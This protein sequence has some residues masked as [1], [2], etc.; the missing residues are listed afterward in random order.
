[1]LRATTLVALLIPFSCVWAFQAPASDELAEARAALTAAR[2]PQA[3]DLFA[4][5]IAKE[6]AN[7]EAYYGVVRA[8]L[9]ARRPAEAYAYAEQG[10]RRAPENA[11]TEDAA[12]IAL[13]RKGELVK[14]EAH[15]R[16][17]LKLRG[18]DPAA[19][20]GMASVFSIISKF[21]TS[22]ALTLQAYAQA[23]NDPV[24]MLAH[25]Y[26]LKGS[27]RIQDLERVLALLDPAS[28][29][30]R[31]LH[32]RIAAENAAAG[33]EL[34]RLI[35]PYESTRV[36]MFWIMDGLNKRRGVHL[37]VQFNQ[38][39]TLR[40]LLDTGASGISIAPRAAE[41]AGL[42]ILGGEGSDA[43]GIGDDKA[44]TAFEYLAAE[45]R[46]GDVAFADYPV[47]VFRGAQSADFDGLIGADVFRQ[48]VIGI[49]FTGLELSLD[50]RPG[51]LK[52]QVGAVDAADTVPKG[53]FR[54]LRF[55]NHLALPTSPNG[56]APVIFLIDSGAT[57][58]LIDVTV[59]RKSSKIYRDDRAIVK[60]VQG[61]VA[62]VNRANDI[63]LAF[64][65]FRQSNPDLLAIDLT[66]MSDD[67][68]VGFAGILGMPVLSQMKLTIDYREGVIRME[69]QQQPLPR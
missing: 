31:D 29:D 46:I 18:N 43:K 61:K 10:L 27:D 45:V 28:E 4:A 68:G 41:K 6:P 39:Q 56:E 13:V 62:E 54:V 67:M 23:P 38:R 59:A 7:A 16:A 11:A 19:L 44:G 58:N 35:T 34:R 22:R 12:G 64:A 20:Q 21:K 63:S 66:K 53:F 33:R 65:G 69:P 52:D 57:R 47:A 42:Q 50:T 60:G 36:K 8:L 32:A 9:G 17:A 15:F 14:A 51:A 26:T 5:V 2:F 40:L 25:A 24:L 55:G 37:R 48:F 1:M 3:A 49:D 30:A